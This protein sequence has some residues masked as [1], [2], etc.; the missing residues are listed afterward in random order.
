MEKYANLERQPSPA[1]KIGDEVWV[2]LRDTTQGYKFRDRQTKATIIN[3]IGPLSYKLDLPG[4]QHKVF[5]P[6]QLRVAL[7]DPLPSQEIHDIRPNPALNE[8]TN[9]MEYEIEKILKKII[10]NK[11][12]GYLVKW[13]GY[14]RPTWEPREV[15]EDT[16]ALDIFLSE[17]T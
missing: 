15:L 5:H 14:N 9:E 12:E 2:R 11:K 7:N 17:D 10:K 13:K 16:E 3:V 1:Y 8:E 6:S 4:R